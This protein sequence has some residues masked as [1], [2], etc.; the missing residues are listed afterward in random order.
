METVLVLLSYKLIVMLVSK[1]GKCGGDPD[2]AV[3][4]KMYSRNTS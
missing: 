4:M 1:L 3:V 2:G